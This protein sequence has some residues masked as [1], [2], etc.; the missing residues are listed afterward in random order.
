MIRGGAVMGR[1]W[2]DLSDDEKSEFRARA[3]EN[4]EK[5]RAMKEQFKSVAHG[6]KEGSFS[7]KLFSFLNRFAKALEQQMDKYSK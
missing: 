1:S 7:K 5:A 2:N 6:K 4:A 3:Q